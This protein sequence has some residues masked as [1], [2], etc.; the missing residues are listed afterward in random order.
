M[1]TPRRQPRSADPP[2]D[3][4]AQSRL[5]RRGLELRSRARARLRHL[6]R[7]PALRQ[8]VQRVPDAVRSRR[9][10]QHRRDRR[11]RQVGLRQGRRPVLSVRPLLHDQVP[12]RAAAS[13]ER[14]LPAPDAARQGAASFSAARRRCATGCSP[15][16]TGSASWRRFRSW[17]QVGQ[18]GDRDA[19]RAQGDGEGARRASPSAGCRH[20]AAKPFRGDR[21]A[22]RRLAGR[23]GAR[24]P[25]KVAIFS[26]CYV[27]LQ[28]ARHRPRPARASSSTTRFPYVRRREGGLLRHAQAR[29]GRSRVGAQ[30]QGDQ[31]PAAGAAG[32]RGL[33]D[34]HRRCR[35]AR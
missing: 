5:L 24:T 6:P 7:L 13:V 1:T 28:R 33:R 32:A 11:R 30:A 18:H 26:T 15:A 27:E 20:Y 34:P 25:G 2:S 23:D 21:A 35:R 19:A 10:E 3:R 8:P 9:R 12:V 29:A 14:R 4:L 16:P 17:S 22:K 31:H